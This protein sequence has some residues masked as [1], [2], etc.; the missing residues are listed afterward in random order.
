L[1]I[2]DT[3]T[4]IK[5]YS[6]PLVQTILPVVKERGFALDLELFV[7]AR[8]NGF[9][10]FVEMPV[11]LHRR[12]SSTISFSTVLAMLRDTAR[13]FWRAKISLRYL[14]SSSGAELKN[15]DDVLARA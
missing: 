4:G 3:Q 13:I 6:A 15:S 7:A 2:S 8:A 12:G 10:H 9:Q 14:R 5:L 1:D 11:T